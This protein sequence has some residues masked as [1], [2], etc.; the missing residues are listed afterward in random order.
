M[1]P[2]AE[3]AALQAE[4]PDMEESTHVPVVGKVEVS[5]KDMKLNMLNVSNSSVVLSNGN[6]I[7]VTVSGI[8]IDATLKWHYREHAWPHISDSGRGEGYTSR[9]AGTVVVTFGSDATGHP[10]ALIS[11][12]D[13]DMSSLSISLHGGASWLYEVFIS[14]FHGRIVSAI[15]GGVCKALTGSVQSQLNEYLAQVPVQHVLGEH[16]A[17]DY[18]LANPNGIVINPGLLIAN[19]AGEFFPQDGQ[20]GKAPGKPAAM[21]DNIADTHFQIFASEFTAESLGY[22]AI[23]T[24]LTEKLV[25]K[26]MAPAIAASFFTTDFYGQYAPGLVEKYGAGTDVALFLAVRQT[27]DVIFSK[28]DGIHVKAG[29]EMTVRGKNSAG[30]F[31][32]AFTMLL[33]CDIL[34]DAKVD[35]SVISGELTNAVA[36]ASLVQSQVGDVD[37]SGFNDLVQFAISMGLDSINQILAKGTPL[38]SIPGVEFVNPAIIYG[39]HYVAVTTNIHFTLPSKAKA[40]AKASKH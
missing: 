4:I 17:I 7:A 11:G 21:P 6:A 35:G 8:T 15:E 22:T 19:S 31:E 1:L 9:A 39:D 18:S 12:C 33:S 37:V 24:G 30:S 20:P 36:T 40:K 10:T 16:I 27:P 32:D 23:Q 25:T 14:L 34:G 28:D 29:I 2:V 26:D 3:S 38:P 13:L 5:L